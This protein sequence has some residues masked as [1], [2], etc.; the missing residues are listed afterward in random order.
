MIPQGPMPTILLVAGQPKLTWAAS[1]YPDVHAYLVYRSA[2]VLAIGDQVASVT[3]DSPTVS[4]ID[5][6]AGF[7]VTLFYR[8]VIQDSNLAIGIPSDAS[9]VDIEDS[10]F[11]HDQVLQNLVLSLRGDAT[12]MAMLANAPKAVRVAYRIST[13]G[14]IYPFVVITRKD[15]KEDPKWRQ[16]QRVA[17][18]LYT[19]EVVNNQPSMPKVTDIFHRIAQVV[20]GEP[21]KNHLSSKGV[22]VA[23][24]FFQGAGPELYDSSVSV[25]SSSASLSLVVEFFPT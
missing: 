24:A 13:M 16:D 1:D 4:Y 17:R 15:W 19:L 18:I 5:A 12:L 2:S 6:G 3:P 8:V 14:D 21:G 9:M 11:V 7:G 20:D 23:W 22:T 10:A 25:W